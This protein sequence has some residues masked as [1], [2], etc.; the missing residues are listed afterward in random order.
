MG[1]RTRLLHWVPVLVLTALAL[2]CGSAPAPKVERR[3]PPSDGDIVKAAMPAI[4]LVVNTRD[5][6]KT[7][8][9]AGFFDADGH[10]LTAHHVVEDKGRVSVM[11]F[12][13]G[14]SSYSPMDGG[15]MRFLFENGRELLPATLIKVDSVSDLA[16]LQIDGDVGQ[17]VGTRPALHWANEG[18]R[19]GDRVYALG[20]PQE[21]PWSFSAGVVGALQYGLIQ[22]DATVGPG[23]SG[24]PLLNLR[25]E[26]VGVNVAQVVSE[27]VGLSFARPASVVMSALGGGGH[28]TTSI[29]LSSATTSAL[30]CWRAQELALREV[31]DCFD[32]ETDW[33]QYT[34]L[35]EEAARRVEPGDAQE[36][37]LECTRDGDMKARWI[38]KRREHVVRALDPSFVKGKEDQ[39]LDPADPDL[40]PDVGQLLREALGD[41]KMV[42]PKLDSFEAD[43]R[44]VMRLR[45]RLRQGLRVEDTRRVAPDQEWVLL[46]SR[47]PDGSVA[48]FSELYVRVGEVWVQRG[49]PWPEEIDRLPQAWPQPMES[50]AAKRSVSLAWLIKRAVHGRTCGPSPEPKTSSDPG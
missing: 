25:G 22:H 33:K 37:L 47:N 8:W 36:R 1:R 15:I 21:T 48:H 20:H 24:G 11:L 30:S 4:V 29:D 39:K 35:V 10:V 49:A 41:Q 34:T 13:E 44:D 17:A 45:T 12:S 28:G 26:V 38:A 6:R 31:E 2:A 27:P 3:L 5:D 14:R 7:T 46:G 16:M 32:W 40:P 50:Y 18:V 19:P 9:G 43:F 42:T 23:S